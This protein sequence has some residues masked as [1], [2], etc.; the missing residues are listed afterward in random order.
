MSTTL[1]D[2]IHDTLYKSWLP[3]GP[4]H[5]ARIVQLHPSDLD[6]LAADLRTMPRYWGAN[7]P[8]RAGF[9]LATDFGDVT[10]E[11]DMTV[12]PGDIRL[13]TAAEAAHNANV[14]G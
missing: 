7:I 11:G 5:M 6:A 12:A 10:V 3:N 9:S 13:L 14:E 4:V 1:L 8:L 2:R